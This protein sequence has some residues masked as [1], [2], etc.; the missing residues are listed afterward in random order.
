M[1]RVLE[2]RQT[3]ENKGESDHFAEIVENVEILKIVEIPAARPL[4]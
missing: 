4:S 3:V 2:N 1:L